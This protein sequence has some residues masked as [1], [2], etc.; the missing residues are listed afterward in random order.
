[1]STECRND[2]LPQ[3]SVAYSFCRASFRGTDSAEN[4][5]IL[6]VSDL[7]AYKPFIFV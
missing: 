4:L 3:A 5:L 1:M 7:F 2:L 6:W